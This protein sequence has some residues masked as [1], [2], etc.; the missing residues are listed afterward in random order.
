MAPKG[1][2]PGAQMDP[3]GVEDGVQIN[4]RGT[5]SWVKW[6]VDGAIMEPRIVTVVLNAFSLQKLIPGTTKQSKIQPD[7]TKMGVKCLRLF[8]AYLPLAR[9]G[10]IAAGN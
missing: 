1:P 10:Y 4:A 2:P 5:K 6:E 7:G 9:S 3:L 8:E